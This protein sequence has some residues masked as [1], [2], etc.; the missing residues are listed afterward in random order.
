MKTF[1]NTDVSRYLAAVKA[2][3][4]KYTGDVEDAREATDFLRSA[5]VHPRS[6]VWVAHG[7]ASTHL[8]AVL[9]EWTDLKLN[10]HEIKVAGNAAVRVVSKNLGE[11]K[12]ELDNPKPRRA[13]K[14]DLRV[15]ALAVM[16]YLREY[17]REDSKDG[18]PPK[19]TTE[20]QYQHDRL[21]RALGLP[22]D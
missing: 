10:H 9:V 13:A 21:A 8:G 3:I 22:V 17:C 6:S 12:D 7:N 11:R 15:A 4:L 18:V 16:G 19:M 1:R 2:A 5:G 20:A 14:P